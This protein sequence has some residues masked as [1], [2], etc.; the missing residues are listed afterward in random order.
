M[1]AMVVRSNPLMIKFRPRCAAGHL[2]LRH[3][4]CAAFMRRAAIKARNTRNTRH[5]R[6]RRVNARNTCNTRHIAIKARNTRN[7]PREA[8]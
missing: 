1:V 8:L 5:L 3:S 2:Y 7:T 6:P 4:Y